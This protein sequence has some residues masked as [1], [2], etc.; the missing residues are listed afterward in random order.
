MSRLKPAAPFVLVLWTSLLWV[1]R[2]DLA[3][4]VADGSTTSRL[5]ATI[6]VVVFV[7]LAGV[8]AVSLWRRDADAVSGGVLDPRSRRAAGVL[9]AWTVGYWLVRLPMILVADHPVPF[10]VVHTV[11]AVV[12]WVI[13][14]WVSASSLRSSRVPGGGFEESPSLADSVG[15]RHR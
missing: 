2:L 5:V 1:G 14:G 9:V 15:G 13:A 7:L 3:W 6:P 12:S 4:T 8:V 10:E 11:L